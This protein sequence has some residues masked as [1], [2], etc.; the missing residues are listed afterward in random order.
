[1]KK[2]EPYIDDVLML[3][4]PN[5]LGDSAFYIERKKENALRK[6]C[7]SVRELVLLGGHADLLGKTP[8]EA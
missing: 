8:G 6:S 3:R 2:D 1:M 4:M 5:L 7:T